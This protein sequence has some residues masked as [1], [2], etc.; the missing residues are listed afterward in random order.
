MPS[1]RGQDVLAVNT[2]GTNITANYDGSTGILLL[3]GTDS[4]AHYQQALGTITYDNS[5]GGPQVLSRTITVIANDGVNQSVAAVA[6]LNVD[7]PP[8]ITLNAGAAASTTTWIHAGPIAVGNL[9]QVLITDGAAEN[10]ASLTV[11]IVAPGLGDLLAVNTTGTGISAS[12]DSVA[13]ILTLNGVDSLAH[14]QQVLATLTYDNANGGPGAPSRTMTVIANDGVSLSGPVAVAVNIHVP[15]V[16]Q[17]DA[18][19]ANDTVTWMNHGPAA[20]ATG[21]HTLVADGESGTLLS[22]T[23]RGRIVC[24]RE[25]SWRPI[26]RGRT[27]LPS[28]IAQPECSR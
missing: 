16:V 26:R 15:P 1:P 28:T 9:N 3:H 12:Y 5:I 6:T 8:V 19:D 4:L 17:L 27:S 25:T 22:L 18:P 24:R 21:G 7:V 2:A 10:L 23:V 20:I 13:G 11:A 14:Y